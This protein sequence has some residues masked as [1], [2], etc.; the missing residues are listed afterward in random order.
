MS[1][2]NTNPVEQVARVEGV[3]EGGTV[4]SG[5]EPSAKRAGPEVQRSANGRDGKG[6]FT[7]GNAGGPGNP[8][9]RE[10]AR[11]RKRLMAKVTDEEMDAI[12][13]KLIEQ[14]KNGDTASVKLLFS[15]TMG[16]PAAA[17]DPE[18]TRRDGMAA[19]EADGDHDERAA[20]DDRAHDARGGLADRARGPADGQR[21][22]E[23][24]DGPRA[25]ASG[26]G[27]AGGAGVG[28][29]AGEEDAQGGR[30]A[31]WTYRGC[32]RR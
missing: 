20:G 25:L 7:T 1:A 8:Y 2:T 29:G 3:P 11:L 10:V 18:S 5:A 14:A 32:R 28:D 23:K 22:V 16:K 21:G 4:A 12:A 13:D 26:G 15:Y 6:R 27:D 30:G 24:E 9:A 19:L 17:A 31:G